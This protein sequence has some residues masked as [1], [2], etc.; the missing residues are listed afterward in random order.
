VLSTAPDRVNFRALIG[1]VFALVALTGL[2]VS[3]PAFAKPSKPEKGPA[4]AA[5]YSPPKSFPSEHGNLIWQRKAGGLNP[6]AGAASNKLVLYTSRT[7][8]GKTVA[9]SGVVSVPK[10]KAPKGGW[11][12]ISYAHGTTGVADSCAPSRVT[13]SSPVAGYVNYINPELEDWIDAGYAVVRTDYQGLGTPGD[14][15]YLVGS[16]EGRGVLDIVSAARQL[17]PDIGKSYLIAGHSQGGHA[18]LFAASE[19]NDYS[20]QLKLKGTVA[21]APASHLLT[22][23]EAL[24]ALTSPSSLSALAAL[25]IKGASTVTP[26]VN[27]PQLLNDPPLA[28]YPQVDQTCLPQ[29][30]ASDSFGGIAPADL[31]R[32]GADTGPLYGV[33]ETEN[34][35]VKTKAPILL[36]QGTADTTVFKTFTDQLNDELTASGDDV[37]YKVFDGV[38]HGEI[39]AAA[40]DDALAFF[41]KRLPPRG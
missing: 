20:P 14:H 16:A 12:V 30:G 6:I 23:A 26:T 5:F 31:L 27:V 40:E 33:L 32:D 39:P 24:P 19:A 7:P 9:V 34:P 17:D 18:A 2:L 29:L 8:Q 28:L 3:A 37:T 41:K 10:G 13:A 22:Q 1:L 36:A 38:T 11:P 35:D 15:P 25:I 21:Y 4:G